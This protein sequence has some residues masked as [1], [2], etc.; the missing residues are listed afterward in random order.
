[1]RLVS[2]LVLLVAGAAAALPRVTAEEAA[3]H[4]GEHVALAGTVSAVENRS[5]G[6][7]LMI[8]SDFPVPV[9]IPASVR[10]QLGQHVADLKGREVELEGTLTAAGEPLELVLDR[11]EAVAELKA[12]A[13]E[14]VEALRERVRELEQDVARLKGAQPEDLTAR[15]YGPN[16]SGPI[17]VYGPT[18]RVNP[19]D[20]PLY[21]SQT[22]VLAQRGVP[23]RTGWG[24]RGPIL[25]YGRERWMFDAK[26]Q[27]IDVRRD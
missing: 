18:P 19:N 11:P 13:G 20:I 8:G 27:L 24:P 2:A 17:N 3:R 25:F 7:I 4:R 15:S 16:G 5:D 23:T 22:K 1:M 21:T 9:R 6:T 12:A 14:D 26:G 10:T